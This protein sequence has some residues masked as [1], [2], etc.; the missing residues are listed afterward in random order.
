VS[1]ETLSW[2]DAV[3]EENVGTS[4]ALGRLRRSGE[5]RVALVRHA[6]G[7]SGV[8]LATTSGGLYVE[9]EDENSARASFTRV[10][11]PGPTRLV[12]SERVASWLMP[13]LTERGPL[14]RTHEPIAMRCAS[15]TIAGGG[16]WA[17]ARDEDRLRAYE[18]A[19]NA[20]RHTTLR[21]DWPKMIEES[22]VAVLE[23]SGEIVCVA[24]KSGETS[25]VACIGGIFTFPEHRRRG[26]GAQVTA[27]LVA[28]RLEERREV[29]L[30]AD[31]DNVAALS[32]YR[33]LGFK[34][35]GRCFIAYLT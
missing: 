13:L 34:E 14:G 25:K 23:D 2:L 35:M 10:R 31:D 18:A 17:V 11:R 12:C 15:L 4:V 30:I 19:Y 28:R 1:N 26:L 16:R 6:G 29:H 33:S 3:A 5:G 7:L 20:E 24:L 9:A 32:L 22:Q 27:F 21:F 8:A